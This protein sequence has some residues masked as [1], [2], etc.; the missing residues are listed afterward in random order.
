VY[1]ITKSGACPKCNGTGAHTHKDFTKCSQCN[2][3]GIT[4]QRQQYP[5]GFYNMVP[6]KCN[7]CQGSGSVVTRACPFC[8]GSKIVPAV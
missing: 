1:S 7:R 2:G 5:N 3:R 8:K 6:S 4:E